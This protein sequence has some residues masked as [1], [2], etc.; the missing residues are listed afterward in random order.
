M[1]ELPQVS[2]RLDDARPT[3]A[4]NALLSFQNESLKKRGQQEDTYNLADL[5]DKIG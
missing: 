2:V 1:E 5:E 4:L 3:A